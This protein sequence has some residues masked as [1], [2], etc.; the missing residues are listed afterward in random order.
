[1]IEGVLRVVRRDNKRGY[2]TCSSAT[3]SVDQLVV[4]RPGLMMRSDDAAAELRYLVEVPEA[5][6][7]EMLGRAWAGE[8]DL[9]ADLETD[10]E[11]RESKRLVFRQWSSAPR[12]RDSE[13]AEKS[14]DELPCIPQH[15]Y[16][17]SAQEVGAFIH[18]QIAQLYVL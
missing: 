5:L 9:V 4:E 6:Q 10:G 12:R 8:F 1:M 2:C 17:S 16:S 18:A 14:Q 3:A 11:N 13:Y 7:A 15:S